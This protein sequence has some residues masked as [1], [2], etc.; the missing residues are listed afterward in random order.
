MSQASRTTCP[1]L[2]EGMEVSLA[3][4]LLDHPGL[5]QEVVVDVTTDRVALEVE[6]DV[7]VLPEPRG[8][9]VAVSLGIP[10][11]LQNI[12]GLE[13]NVFDSFNLVLLGHV[14]Y[15]EVD[16]TECLSQMAVI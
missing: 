15:L 4:L 9:V 7:H 10:K 3:L 11:C 2:V 1:H 14:G 5:L 6:V 13:E 8:V 16:Q 12:V